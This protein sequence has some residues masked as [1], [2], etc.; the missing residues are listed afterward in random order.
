MIGSGAGEYGWSASDMGEYWVTVVG[1]FA[2]EHP[3]SSSFVVALVVS[4]SE[5]E[6]GLARLN[7]LGGVTLALR[8]D[9]VM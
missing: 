2:G 7:V 3:A 9:R 6:R 1:W 5:E 8:D 4:S